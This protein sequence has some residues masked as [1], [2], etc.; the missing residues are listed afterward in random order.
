MIWMGHVASMGDIRNAYKI[1]IRKHKEKRPLGRPRHRW[2]D[3]IRINLGEIGWGVWIGFI[4]LRIG[5][6]GRVLVKTAMTLH[7]A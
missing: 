5:T 7:V 2:E 1:L 3:N 4:C 6:S